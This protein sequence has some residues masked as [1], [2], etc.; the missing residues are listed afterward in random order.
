MLKQLFIDA[1][2]RIELIC[3]MKL[4]FKDHAVDCVSNSIL[5]IEI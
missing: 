4:V 3:M 2:I 5:D 1:G